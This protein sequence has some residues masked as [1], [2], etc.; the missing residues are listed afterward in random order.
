MA[1]LRFFLLALAFVIPYRCKRIRIREFWAPATFGV[2]IGLLSADERAWLGRNWQKLVG[3]SGDQLVRAFP[4]IPDYIDAAERRLIVVSVALSILATFEML[5]RDPRRRR[6]IYSLPKWYLNRQTISSILGVL[7]GDLVFLLA[8]GAVANVFLV[9]YLA[10]PREL[11][12]LNT[13]SGFIVWSLYAWSYASILNVDW[14]IPSM[15]AVSI[16]V[17]LLVNMAFELLSPIVSVLS[18]NL[19]DIKVQIENR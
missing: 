19:E 12:S 11:P 18:E 1:L 6:R 9:Y 16:L 13:I 7:P 14:R 10:L 2:A 17:A 5:R 15:V 3:W 8:F 4:N